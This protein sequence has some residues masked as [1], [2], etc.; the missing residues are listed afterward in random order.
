LAFEE[1]EDRPLKT[2]FG[3]PDPEYGAG[4]VADKLRV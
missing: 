3:A 1:E 4:V 2:T